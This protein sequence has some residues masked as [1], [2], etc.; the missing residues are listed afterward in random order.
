MK[1]C[2]ARTAYGVVPEFGLFDQSFEDVTDGLHDF[3]N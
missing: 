2:P 3:L 1:T